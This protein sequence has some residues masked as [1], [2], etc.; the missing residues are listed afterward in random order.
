MICAH[1]CY[2]LS[3]LCPRLCLE[4]LLLWTPRLFQFLSFWPPNLAIFLSLWP[5]TTSYMLHTDTCKIC[6]LLKN[7]NHDSKVLMDMEYRGDQN[8]LGEGTNNNSYMVYGYKRGR[9]NESLKLIQK[10]KSASN[11]VYTWNPLKLWI[12]I[13]LDQY[14]SFVDYT[15]FL[16][17]L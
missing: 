17:S 13:F 16:I 9:Q 7:S 8:I 3:N 1:F 4:K 5:I 14:L 11:S 2:L 15:C 6:W 12:F 10:R